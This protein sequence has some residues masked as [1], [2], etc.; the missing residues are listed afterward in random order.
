MIC[1]FISLLILLAITACEVRKGEPIGIIV[2]PAL[3][4]QDLYSMHVPSGMC[5]EEETSRSFEEL[6]QAE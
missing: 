1:K 3:E 5:M 4:A 2:P 6:A